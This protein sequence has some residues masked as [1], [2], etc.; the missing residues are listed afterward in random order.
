MR[1]ES[2]ST[3][4]GI[5]VTRT[6]SKVPYAR[7]LND[8]LHKLDTQRGVYF[9]SGY[10]YPERYARWDFTGV[11]PPL[12]IIA[13]GRQ[14]HFQPL[15]S[16]GEILNRIFEPLLANHPHWENFA[17]EL[18]ALRGT[19]KPLP[20]LF[21]E[22]ER[23]KQPSAFSILRVLLDEFRNPISSRLALVGAFGYDLLFQFD[24]IKLKLPRNGVKDLHLF[25]CDEMY[26]MDRKK[27][28][29]ERFQYDF[30]RGDLT[31]QGVKRS[32]ARLKKP[33]PV[34]PGPIVS[35]HRPDEYMAKVE[36]VREGMRRGDYYE[37]VLRQTFRAPYS[38][39][40]SALFEKIQQA[41]QPLRIFSPIR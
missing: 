40:P 15:N 29:I 34:E 23:S 35:D 30:S 38:G 31:T 26:F 41:S 12:E 32:A 36:T 14:I 9:S 13:V 25:L 6:I 21:P 7:G 27:E 4:S 11:A 37:V 10:E 3:P 8:L 18:G 22:E 33:K 5:T 2:Y 16:R 39:S 28:Q 17:N 1:P 20:E 19:L 24:P